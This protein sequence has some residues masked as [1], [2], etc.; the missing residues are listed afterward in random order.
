M[1]I[2]RD[3]GPAE[4]EA[5]KQRDVTETNEICPQ[6]S[7]ADADSEHHRT[8]AAN[9]ALQEAQRL[10]Y[11]GGLGHRRGLFLNFG[12]LGPEFKPF[13]LMLPSPSA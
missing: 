2:Q 7:Q 10:S 12:C 13:V 3:L 11:I 4:V 8:C 5:R 1:E 6:I 9:G